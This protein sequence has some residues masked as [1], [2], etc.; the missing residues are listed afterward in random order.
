MV[1]E[2]KAISFEHVLIHYDSD[3]KVKNGI[4]TEYSNSFGQYCQIN[5][6]N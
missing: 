5:G 3:G 4:Y 6:K 2:R 1:K